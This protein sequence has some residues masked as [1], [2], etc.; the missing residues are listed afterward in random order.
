M[1]CIFLT[2][3]LL[4]IETAMCLA[5]FFLQSLLWRQHYTL[6]FSHLLFA[7]YGD[8]IVP[9]I[10]S[11]FSLLI[12]R[13]HGTLHFSS[14]IVLIMETYIMPCMFFLHCFDYGDSI[15][16]C[17]VFFFLHSV[18][19]GDNIMPCIFSSFILLIMETT[20]CL[21]FFLPSFC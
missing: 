2:F 11:C 17:L 4:V 15:I 8:C 21:A 20:L 14:F 12:W 16:L 10:F 3:I 13:Q 1:P 9:C 18:N 5:F 19:Y 6:H 7:N